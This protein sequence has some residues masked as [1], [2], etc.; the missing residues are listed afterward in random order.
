M[1]GRCLFGK[2]GERKEHINTNDKPIENIIV[3]FLSLPDRQ[4]VVFVSFLPKNAKLWH[5]NRKNDG[6][7][8]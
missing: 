2:T 1:Q 7:I 8:H 3:P 6:Y 5:K 4:N